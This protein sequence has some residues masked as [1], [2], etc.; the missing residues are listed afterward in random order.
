[1]VPTA[2][3]ERV[4][5]ENS[6]ATRVRGTERRRRRRI[7]AE[8]IETALIVALAGLVLFKGTQAF[9]GIALGIGEMMMALARL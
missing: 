9:A 5:M 8:I 1:M 4:I 7:R 2:A 6:G 3:S